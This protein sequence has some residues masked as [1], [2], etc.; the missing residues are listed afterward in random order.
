M[1]VPLLHR[2]TQ[3]V[4]LK[5]QIRRKAKELRLRKR[6]ARRRLE[7]MR[8]IRDHLLD[9]MRNSIDVRQRDAK[10]ERREQARKAV[11]GMLAM[12]KGWLRNWSRALR[13]QGRLIRHQEQLKSR[14]HRRLH[15]LR[16]QLKKRRQPQ[17][18]VD[19]C[20][21]KLSK[22]VKKWK[23]S[24]HYHQFFEGQD[25]IWEAEAAEVR[26]YL[27]DIR[28]R[29][30]KKVRRQRV[31]QDDDIDDFANFW[32]NEVLR[33]RLKVKTRLPVE[34]PILD[35]ELVESSPENNRKSIRKIRK[36]KHKPIYL[37]LD[38]LIIRKKV[39]KLRKLKKTSWQREP[40]PSKPSLDELNILVRELIE[41]DF[42]KKDK[43]QDNQKTETSKKVI[44]NRNINVG[45][46]PRFPDI[47]LF[48]ESS[49]PKKPIRK[50]AKQVAP[51]KLKKLLDRVSVPE[52]KIL[53]AEVL[54]SK[55]LRKYKNKIT[56]HKKKYV[57]LVIKDELKALLKEKARKKISHH[58][59]H[60]ATA[61]KKSKD[62]LGKPE[63]E[64][65]RL[66]SDIPLFMRQPT[67]KKKFTQHPKGYYSSS[68][69]STISKEIYPS[70]DPGKGKK[71][72]K[73]RDA[74]SGSQLES[75]VDLSSDQTT[76]GKRKNRSKAPAT[77]D[78]TFRYSD[79]GIDY[80]L[81]KIQQRPKLKTEKSGS[82][83]QF[84]GDS[85]ISLS[86]SLNKI[87][88]SN[89]P[90]K[91][92]RR[93][94]RGPLILPKKLR[95]APPRGQG[96]SHY[97]SLKK[98]IM[99]IRPSEEEASRQR[100]S[101]RNSNRASVS[102]PGFSSARQ[103]KRLLP[104][105]N[106]ETYLYEPRPTNRN[107]IGDYNPD[108]TETIDGDQPHI[109]IE[110]M[111]AKSGTNSR[112]PSKD[113][114][115]YELNYQ[116]LPDE[117]E[118][119]FDPIRDQTHNYDRPDKTPDEPAFG[120]RLTPS[121]GRFALRDLKSDNTYKPMQRFLKDV[122]ENNHIIEYVADVKGL[123]EVVGNHQMWA[124]LHSFHSELIESGVSQNEVKQM[125]S[126]K[127]LDNLQGI[128][129]DMNFAR[130]EPP[131][132]SSLNVVEADPAKAKQASQVDRLLERNL[133][134]KQ[135]LSTRL[136][137][138]G[139]RG[140][141]GNRSVTPH[142]RRPS[143]DIRMNSAMYK[144]LID[145]ELNAERLE[146]EERKRQTFSRFLGSYGSSVSLNPSLDLAPN[147]EQ[148]MRDIETRYSLHNIK[149][150]MHEHNMMF[151]AMERKKMNAEMVHKKMEGK[152][153]TK[154]SA[155]QIRRPTEKSTTFTARK[156]HRNL[157]P[158]E[159]LYYAPR[160]TCRLQRISESSECL[161]CEC[162][163]GEI[164]DS[165]VLEKCPR[166]GVKVPVP[167][168]TPPFSVSSSSS[169]QILSSGS[170]QA[171]AKNELLVNALA[172]LCTRCGYVHGKGHPCSQLPF[173]SQKAEHLKR[174]KDTMRTPPECP[175]FC[176]PCGILKK[177]R[178]FDP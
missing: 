158:I 141:K 29:H 77:K 39:K 50:K 46:I 111:S 175:A 125:L 156:R 33:K 96:E 72:R 58:G 144:K 95:V 132:D 83:L 112:S 103:S 137:P 8:R 140:L 173:Y 90:R 87:I 51:I 129:N 167:G 133:W 3:M 74:S 168:P 122:I 56:K 1:Q 55:K 109:Q 21:H 54:G 41:F 106:S 57:D 157:R 62:S 45:T 36:F 136:I 94:L 155:T 97:Q 135:R 148:D 11:G 162:R 89:R 126:T 70:S 18:L 43:Y 164:G 92:I 107:L 115:K 150:M 30:P 7:V 176:S 71:G 69:S 76:N 4:V 22:A 88:M 84:A 116:S 20:F 178:S 117:L 123:M 121:H 169:S 48:P 101:K 99:Y 73:L 60:K 13:L 85:V 34:G 23:N 139:I 25:Q 154:L 10:L 161:G 38:E 81:T 163:E 47:P 35:S 147:E 134:N 174:I 143:Q 142:S 131:R 15:Q 102:E 68:S 26:K 78:P 79:S 53:K 120:G 119:F 12:Y 124:K 159:Q 75:V 6:K 108:R 171:C 172:D 27:S 82:P 24:P 86:D 105:S 16:K 59:R 63:S 149:N 64:I 2:S 100:R 28:G 32:N 49:F 127:Y 118:K 67:R 61:L 91:S 166:C 80:M 146:R 110:E 152:L 52:P 9:R 98:D 145:Q 65:S 138:F 104:K 93:S 177:T 113:K 66:F 151:K 170:I 19:K 17:K 165:M 114:M 40:D 5:E 160:K 128:V 31:N 37:S 14:L 44:K 130:V 153:G 42:R